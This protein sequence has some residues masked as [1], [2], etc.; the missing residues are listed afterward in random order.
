MQEN[1]WDTKYGALGISN[2]LAVRNILQILIRKGVITREEAA[3]V[4]TMTA[5]QVRDGSED[6]AAPHYGESVA[7]SLEKSASWFLGKGTDF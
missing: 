6:G 4:L 7:R 1:P 3:E 2:S 5:N